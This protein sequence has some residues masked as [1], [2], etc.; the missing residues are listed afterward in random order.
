MIGLALTAISVIWTTYNTINKIPQI[1]DTTTG[2]SINLKQVAKSAKGKETT[3]PSTLTHSQSSDLYDLPIL[4]YLLAQVAVVFLLVA[5]YY[6][7]ILT[8]WAT[9]QSNGDIYEPRTG[10]SSMWI[11]AAGQ[12]I[13]IT[14]YFWSLIAPKVLTNRDFN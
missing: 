7:M 13:A 10:R 9:Y 12:W 6:A 4:K 14:F 3:A 11:Q 2:E 5:G 1:T 8:N